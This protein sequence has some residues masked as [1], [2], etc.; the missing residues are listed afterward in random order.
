MSR[1][2]VVVTRGAR[3]DGAVADAAHDSDGDRV[4]TL[5]GREVARV[6]RGERYVVRMLPNGRF[7]AVAAGP[8]VAAA[9]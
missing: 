1:V 3:L 6:A 9:G 4:F 8:R 7:P 2:L 5:R